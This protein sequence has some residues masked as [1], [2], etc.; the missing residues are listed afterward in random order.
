MQPPSRAWP[1]ALQE[2]ARMRTSSGSTS[3]QSKRACAYTFARRNFCAAALA[4]AEAVER[5][6]AAAVGGADPILE[7][8]A[9]AKRKS[10][11]LYVGGC[12]GEAGWLNEATLTIPV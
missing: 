8:A 10:D 6:G 2:R 4:H 5:E 7:E 3:P 9:A 12:V 11:R 1:S